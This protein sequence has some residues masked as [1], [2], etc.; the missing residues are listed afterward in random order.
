M[1]AES[2]IKRAVGLVA[3]ECEIPA[4]V[5]RLRAGAAHDDHAAV[6]LY[7]R[8]VGHRGAA[9]RGPHDAARAERA[10]EPAVGPVANER[11]MLAGSLLGR[12]D[13][14]DRAA[15]SADER[16]RHGAE[17]RRDDRARAALAIPCWGSS[18]RGNGARDGTNGRQPHSNHSFD[19]STSSLT[20]RRTAAPRT[21]PERSRASASFASPSS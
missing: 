10:V 1:L 5:V 20:T 12:S 3:G 9:D 13:G 16:R 15:G 14:D 19:V 21:S 17:R 11:E 4:A 6:T 2:R 7:H 18:R 8:I